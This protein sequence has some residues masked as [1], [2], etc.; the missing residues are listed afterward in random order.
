MKLTYGI[1]ATI[2]VF[3]TA[4]VKDKPT[5]ITSD[6]IILSNSKKV[7]VINEGNFMNNNASVSLFDTG[8]NSVVENYYNAQNNAALG[9]VA[10]SISK[11][12]NNYYIVVNN[13]NK[14]VVVDEK[15]KL[16]R[17][18]T[19]LTSPRYI[20]QVSNQKAYVS[21]LYA[22]AIS[23]IDLNNGVKT[24]S[25]SLNG[26]TEKM[27]MLYN[28][29]FVTNMNKNYVYV[30]NAVNDQITDSVFVGKN[31]GSIECDKNDKLWVLGSGNSSNGFLTRIDPLNLS[32][33]TFS[34]TSSDSPHN[35]CINGS[36]DTLFYLNNGIFKMGI[37]ELNLPSAAFIPKGTKN[38]YGLG[39]HPTTHDI[40][41]SDALDYI[42]RSN[43]YIYNANNGTQKHTFK[44]GINANGFYFE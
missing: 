24:G 37:A 5:P 8:N 33:S 38:Y 39:V 42:Q 6:T 30:I 18:I 12:N 35:L 22:N 4:C 28:K 26:W 13:S 9:D 25:I 16:K 11:I 1:L 10:Q 23:I 43:I 32:T 34:F 15:F 41:A 3:F 14:I 2:L 27:V 21:D 20:Q 29:V 7:Y 17:S 40:Y 44:A 36:K 19:G 31:A